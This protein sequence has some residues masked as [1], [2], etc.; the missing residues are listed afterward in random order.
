MV[1]RLLWRR[2]ESM[3]VSHLATHRRL[4]KPSAFTP[5]TS[6][7]TLIEL[8]VV[9][10]I[11]ALLAAI[12]FPV[13]AQAREKARTATCQSNM[14]QLGLGFMQ[15]SQDYDEQPPNGYWA[16]AGQ[17]LHSGGG[18]AGQVYTYTKNTQIFH[19]PNDTTPVNWG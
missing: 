19:C 15:Y 13:F 9:I 4:G 6:A 3:P 11:I 8:L 1:I 12:L 16:T 2:R 14:K 7:F 18:W 17:C 10:A 5:I